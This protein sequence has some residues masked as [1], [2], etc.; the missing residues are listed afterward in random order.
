MADR[1]GPGWIAERL[2][3]ARADAARIAR[4][5][6]DRGH[7]SPAQVG[8][9]TGAVDAAIE[10]GRELITEALR[11]TGRVLDGLRQPGAPGR[12][13]STAVATGAGA[14]AAQIQALEA[15]IAALEEALL[16]GTHRTRHGSEGD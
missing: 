9:I 15:R 14:Q 13:D 16:C 11:E 8:A 2:S 1:E 7:L 12:G 6:A 4:E 10:R 3:N 5:L